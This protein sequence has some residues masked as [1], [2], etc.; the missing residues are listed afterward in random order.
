MELANLI[1][2]ICEGGAERAIIYILLDNRLLIFSREQL[3]D[4]KIIRC[5]TGEEFER[6]YLR[7]S[8]KDKISVIRVLDSKKENFKLGKAYQYMVDVINIITAPEI[9]M[10]II[11]N[12]NKF[13]E[14]NRSQYKKPTSD[15]C[16]S[17]LKMAS[18]KKY[19]FVHNYFSDPNTLISAIR[20]HHRLSN[21]K[22]LDCD[23]GQYT[24]LDILK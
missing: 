5:R 11:C 8:F 21:L 17:C 23:R 24:L 1:A 4:E 6:R 3:L 19:E 7:K 22:K 20:K 2:C 9:E 15:F 16:K 10:L 14:F 18:V 12:E 13:N